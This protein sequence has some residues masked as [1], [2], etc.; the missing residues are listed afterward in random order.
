MK[1]LILVLVIFALIFNFSAC[2]NEEP[3]TDNTGDNGSTSQ[4]DPYDSSEDMDDNGSNGQ[5]DSGEPTD[6]ADDSNDSIDDNN[7]ADEEPEEPLDAQIEDAIVIEGM[8]EPIVLNLYE[9]DATSFATYYPTNFLAE[10]TSTSD[11]D[12]YW[13]YANYADVKIEDLYLQLYFFPNS[14]NLDQVSVD[15]ENSFSVVL[16]SMDEVSQDE[17]LYDWTIKEFISSGE[18]VYAMMG[19]HDSQ[20]FVMFLNYYGE[21]T[22]GFVPRA[23]K[24]IEHFYWTD[25]QEYLSE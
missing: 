10:K 14:F 25:T 3:N 23:N 21:Y 16:N 7:G 1:K 8:E 24:I 11:G 4:E 9:D 17:N 20:Y 5:D 22:E 2:S 12:I 15:P 19:L 13:F 6:N 18:P